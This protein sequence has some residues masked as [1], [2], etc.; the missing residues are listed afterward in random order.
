MAAEKALLL[1]SGPVRDGKQTY[2]LLEEWAPSTVA[3]KEPFD[4]DAALAGRTHALL[5]QPRP[6]TVGRFRLV[7]KPECRRR[8]AGIEMNGSALEQID[9][10]GE[11][12]WW[13]G[14]SGGSADSPVSPKSA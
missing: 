2:A 10:A 14:D 6:G 9:V 3:D 11:R 7:V 12:F 5:H 1:A 8:Q 4:R 13:A